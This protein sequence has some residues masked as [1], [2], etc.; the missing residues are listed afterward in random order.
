VF[1][2]LVGVPSAIYGLLGLTVFVGLF[3]LGAG[4]LAAALT[5]AV[6]IQPLIVVAAREALR[7]VPAGLRE[8][9]LAIG[10]SRYRT[11]RH[12]VLPHALPG[13]LTGV[14][15]ALAQ[16]IGE[17]APLLVVGL[18]TMAALPTHIAGVLGTRDPVLS[19]QAA[20]SVVI[21]LGVLLVINGAAIAVRS[22]RQTQY[23]L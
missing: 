18:G 3:R 8:G 22:R 4:P 5:L 1:T 14:I 2:N 15:L 16:A 20:A 21:L 12:V 17:A 19:V 10:A 23:N 13:M 7:Q 6:L 11:I 9:A